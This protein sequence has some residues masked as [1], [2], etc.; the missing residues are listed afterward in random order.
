VSQYGS[1]QTNRKV[2]AKPPVKTPP[3]MYVAGLCGILLG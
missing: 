1:R 2:S 3:Q